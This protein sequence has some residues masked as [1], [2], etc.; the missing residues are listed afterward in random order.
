MFR[1]RR[2]AEEYLYHNLEE[3]CLEDTGV[4]W[5]LSYPGA[6]WPRAALLEHSAVHSLYVT[7][8]S[9][10]GAVHFCSPCL[11]KRSFC[12]LADHKMVAWYRVGNHV[13]ISY[14]RSWLL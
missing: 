1:Q 6:R 8:D 12:T 4:T 14:T 11:E 2:I 3:H 13:E 7:F 5:Y 9:I 10:C